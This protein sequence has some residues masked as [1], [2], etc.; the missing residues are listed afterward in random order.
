MIVEIER[1]IVTVNRGSFTKASRTLFL[2]QP[3]LSLSIAR[4]EKEIGVKLFKR[5]GKRLVLTKDG[6]SVYQIGMQ[7][8]RL[9]GKIKDFKINNSADIPYAIGIYDNAA[10]K[11][12]KY[13]KKILSKGD[14]KFEITIGNSNSL[15]QRMRNGLLDI[16][17]CAI[18]ENAF[19]DNFKLIKKF[20]EEL[21]PVSSKLW[22]KKS[23]KAPFILYNKESTTRQYIDKTFFTNSIKPEVIVEST[24]T[25][26]MKE[27]AI[28][29]CGIAL[30]PFN[31]VKRELENKKLFVKKFPF[32]FKRA[33]GLYLSKDGR[34][35]ETDEIIREI[36][37]NLENH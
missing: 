28:G 4:L 35:K 17:I 19:G 9:W 8:I 13:F 3:T 32:K 34:L 24:S 15:M 11:L 29:G 7:I 33:I 14:V 10:L 20:S 6:E 25:V 21:V 5:I 16:C 1:F 37:N 26:F 31:V 12:S 30:L 22:Q 18:R 23:G 27:L 2:T 36:I